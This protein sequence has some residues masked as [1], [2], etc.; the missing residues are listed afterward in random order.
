[1]VAPRA[2]SALDNTDKHRLLLAAT[3]S[4]RIGGW[5]LR[6]EHG[7]GKT[8]PHHSFAALQVDMRLKVGDVPNGFVLPNLAHAVCFMEPGPLFGH[9]MDHSLRNLSQRTRQTV[10][11]F[12]DC[13]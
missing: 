12:A 13:F 9:P 4:I 3:S 7:Y 5:N 6:D 2:S 8:M 1:M 11:S 10:L